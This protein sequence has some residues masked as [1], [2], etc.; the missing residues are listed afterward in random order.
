MRAL[1]VID[2]LN[3]F[4]HPQGVLYVGEQV[5]GVIDFCKKLVERRR[6]EGNPLFFICDTHRK[7]DPEFAMFPPHCIEGEWGNRVLEELQPQKDDY[8]IPKRRFNAFFGTPLDMFLREIKAEEL[9]VVGVCTNICVLYTVA[10]ARMLGYRVTVYEQGVTS[11]DL[12]AHRFALKE[13]HNTLG[14]EVV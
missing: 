5:R 2:M 11:F 6:S 14:A 4:V 12:D 10:S 13:M 1:L 8:V 3:D 7:D 9:E